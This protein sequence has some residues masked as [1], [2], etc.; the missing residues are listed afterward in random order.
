MA[1]NR[2]T[3]VSRGWLMLFGLIYCVV[4]VIFGVGLGFAMTFGNTDKMIQAVTNRQSLTNLQETMNKSALKQAAKAG[5]DLPQT[6]QLIDPQ[7][8]KHGL[9]TGLAISANF[10]DVPAHSKWVDP[11]YINKADPSNM[12][13]E[14]LLKPLNQRLAVAAKHVDPKYSGEVRVSVEKAIAAHYNEMIL[15]TMMMHGVGIAYPMMVLI[16]QTAAIVGAILGVIVLTVMRICSH[17]WERWLRVTGRLTY[18]IAI[19]AGLGALVA[20]IPA[21]AQYIRLGGI[22]QIVI[23]QIQAAAAPTWRILA[24]VILI[25]GIAMSI[26]A[27][28]MRMTARRRAEEVAKKIRKRC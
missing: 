20:S 8:L 17:S 23:E 1:R 18:S 14:P 13:L 19:L 5:V 25:I 3:A 4:L 24:G 9:E 6:T 2:Y 7:A 12:T 11:A 22:S 26:A 28:I 10:G 27:A 15:D 16:C 21:L